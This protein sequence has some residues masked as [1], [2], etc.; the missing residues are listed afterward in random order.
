MLSRYGIPISPRPIQKLA[1]VSGPKPAL[2]WDRLQ[3]Y[4]VPFQTEMAAKDVGKQSVADK[5]DGTYE[6]DVILLNR[7]IL[8]PQTVGPPQTP[9]GLYTVA[10]NVL[11]TFLYQNRHMFEIPETDLGWHSSSFPVT[12]LNSVAEG[13][14]TIR[15]PERC[16]STNGSCAA[17]DYASSNSDNSYTFEGNGG[18]SVP[19]VVH[20]ELNHFVMKR[21]F[22]V[23][24]VEGEVTTTNPA[25]ACTANPAFFGGSQGNSTV[26]NP[27]GCA[28]LANDFNMVE[29]L[30]QAEF[31]VG[32]QP[33]Q[34]WAQYIRNDE[35]DDLDTGWLAGFNWGRAANPMT[36]EF[37][38]AYGV[39]E[40]D[41]QFGQ[42]VD[43]D[44][45]GGVT[46]VDGSIFKIGYA[47]AKNWL[48]NGTYF[49]NKRFVD[50]GAEDLS[51]DRYQ[52]DLNWKF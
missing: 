7:P 25:L 8:P 21:Y 1:A 39:V 46:D 15:L 23:G 32:G 41:A 19:G 31:A 5:P 33:L 30:A 43:S 11:W 26:T 22:D 18:Y 28:T 17:G 34:L 48:L 4:P 27:A 52:I 35:A 3:S 37:G 50:A 36:W 12:T 20:H 42:F 49:M 51:Y 29:A 2:D 24:S 13:I 16:R 40:K 10:H 47:P 44:F 45:G 38:Y 6:G 9:P 14:N